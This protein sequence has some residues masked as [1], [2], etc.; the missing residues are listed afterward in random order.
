MLP[1]SYARY[2]YPPSGILDSVWLSV[3]FALSYRD[4]EELLAE[5]GSDVSHETIR[6]WVLKFGPT[7]A[8]RL[9]NQRPRPSSRRHLD[10]MVVFIGRKRMYLWRAVDD[11]GE[12][13]DVLVQPRQNV[14][15]AWKLIR[16]LL[17]KQGF[18]PSAWA[19][20][21]SRDGERTIARITRI[22][23]SE[24]GNGSFSD[25]NQLDR[26]NASCPFAPP[27]AIRSTSSTEEYREFESRLKIL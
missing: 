1:I 12:V 25:P 13:L 8:K 27:S 3:R 9:R 18:A 14:T 16:T 2:Q 17:K 22:C 10:D 19:R 24:G 20:G 11:E 4:V 26:L 15:A 5:P 23:R 21:M 7:V 6:R